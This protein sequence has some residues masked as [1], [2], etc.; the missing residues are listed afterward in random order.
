MKVD[1]DPSKP[2]QIPLWYWLL[3][4]LVILLV[5]G[6]GDART[7]EQLA[8]SDFKQLLKAGK[9]EE[10]LV[11]NDTIKGKLLTDG[12]DK[13]L[14]K[15][16]ADAL[17]Q[18][19]APRRDF[20]TVRVSDPELTGELD[21]AGVHYA[22]QVRSEWLATMLSW[23]LPL[24]LILWLSSYLGRRG[25]VGA[26]LA[27]DIG[28][29]K[30]RAYVENATG[31]SFDDVAGIDE[32]KEELREIVDFL[33]NPQRYHRLGGKIP[34][35]V[36]IVGAPGTGKTLLAKAVAGEAGVPFFSISGSEFV[37]MFVGV[38]A[39]R[40]RDL[41][42]Q[43]EQK[44]PCIVFIDELDALGKARG[45]GSLLGGHSEQE[46]TLNQLLV[47]MDGFD[48]NKGVIILAAT[49][50]PEILDPAL[51]RPGRFDRHVAV[52][53]PDLKGREQILQVHARQVRLAPQVELGVIAARTAG[54]AGADLANLVNEATLLAA[55]R[56]KDQV[57]MRDFDEAIDRVVAGL[58]KKT[59][60]MN[61]QEKE[62]VAY[63]E[64]GHAL[65]AEFRRYAD[66]VAKISIIP[67]GLAALGYTQQLPTEDRYLLKRSELYDRIDVL[68]GGRVAEEVVF[69][70]VSTGAQNDLQT[71]T[72]LARHMVTQYGM[73]ERLGLAT[74]EQARAPY[75]NPAAPGERQ[76]YSEHTAVTIDAEIARLLDE[77]HKRVLATLRERRGLLDALARM[78]LEHE[79][80]DRG[81]LDA[82]VHGAAGVKPAAL[83]AAPP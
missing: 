45:S 76:S 23:L 55:R 11:G 29:S 14:P 47:E 35:G 63:H 49:N 68:L 58:E 62:T 77:A 18:E 80:V 1:Q 10:L 34:K 15:P 70:D 79:T 46:Q 52:D 42:A 12:L 82:L 8:Y 53:R 36:L 66:R 67:R 40:V 33:K 5:Q 50:R 56:G 48:A 51:L 83:A 59:R 41:F 78:L 26:G 21:A 75:L 31:V 19:G 74:F 81:A 65:I 30:A 73:S 60:L 71:A 28:K 20:I 17:R 37:E 13:V 64:A 38:G 2:W 61:P 25:G 16:R 32:A 57:D 27:F 22:G 3:L 24:A 39:A 4:P 9:V 44:A 7:T 54:F 72:G 43:A 6:I 69:G